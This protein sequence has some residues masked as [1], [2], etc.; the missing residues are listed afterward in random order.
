MIQYN[1]MMNTQEESIM[2]ALATNENSTLERKETK[3]YRVLYTTLQSFYL[4]GSTRSSEHVE[5][6]HLSMDQETCLCD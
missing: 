3:E 2:L 1:Y 6:Q 4:K 5:Q